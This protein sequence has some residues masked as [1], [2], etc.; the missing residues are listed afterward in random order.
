MGVQIGRL[1]GRGPQHS[2]RS[3]T[4]QRVLQRLRLLLAVLLPLASTAYLRVLAIAPL[5]YLATAL[6]VSVLAAAAVTTTCVPAR[7][8]API[9][10]VERDIQPRPAT[11]STTDAFQQ[12]LPAALRGLTLEQAGEAA[13]AW[14]RTRR[15]W[16]VDYA[17]PVWNGVPV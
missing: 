2:A 12:L 10:L 13:A 17:G 3:S 9:P 5:A 11:D 7:A 15:P 8:P 16:D 4:K 6:F 1:D 14:V